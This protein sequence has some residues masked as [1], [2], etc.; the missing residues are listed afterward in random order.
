[1]SGVA[2]FVVIGLGAGLMANILL[3]GGLPNFIVNC[4]AGVIGAVF[5]GFAYRFVYSN[6]DDQLYLMLAATAGA[7]LLTIDMYLIQ[8]IVME[9]Q[10][11]LA[12]LDTRTLCDSSSFGMEQEEH[13]APNEDMDLERGAVF[14]VPS[15][16]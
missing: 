15:L 10:A 11:V 3:K 14:H 6:S 2:W 4:F 13:D 8:N 1:M 16:V 12:V 9:R 7:V 5:G